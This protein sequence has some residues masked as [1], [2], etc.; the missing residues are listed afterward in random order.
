MNRVG[1]LLGA[2]AKRHQLPATRLDPVD[3]L[4]TKALVHAD[5]VHLSKRSLSEEH[6]ASER[7]EDRKP[8]GEEDLSLEAAHGGTS[9]N[10][11]RNSRVR[12][13]RQI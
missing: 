6:A 1:R 11:L 3:E 5:L 13:A 10:S 8:D 12:S 4:G 2:R 9:R 7:E